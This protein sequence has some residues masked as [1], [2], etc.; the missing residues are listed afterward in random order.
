MTEKENVQAL[1]D[2]ASGEEKKRRGGYDEG[3]YASEP[4]FRDRRA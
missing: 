3:V 2:C 1:R 4:V